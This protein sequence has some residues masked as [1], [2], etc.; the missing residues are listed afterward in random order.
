MRDCYNVIVGCEGPLV[1]ALV[2]NVDGGK[3]KTGTARASGEGR[4]QGGRE[5]KEEGDIDGWERE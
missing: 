1:W 2:L 3:G 4:R 5:G